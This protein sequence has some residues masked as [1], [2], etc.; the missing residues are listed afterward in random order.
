MKHISQVCCILITVLIT[1][2]IMYI[3]VPYRYNYRNDS[4]FFSNTSMCRIDSSSIKKDIGEFIA[5]TDLKSEDPV[6]IF[7]DGMRSPMKKVSENNNILVIQL[8][9]SASGST[10]MI[11][12]FKDTGKF[13][14]EAKGNVG[15]SYSEM[16]KGQCRS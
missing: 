3:F 7:P 15:G 5:L 9:A 11:T 4:W 1:I 13:E 10:D 12:I 2:E 6:A 8:V 14:R 16:W